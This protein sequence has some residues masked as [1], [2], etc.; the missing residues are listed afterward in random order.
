MGRPTVPDLTWWQADPDSWELLS[1][2]GRYDK[3]GLPYDAGWGDREEV[4]EMLVASPGPYS[5]DFARHLL[6][7]EILGHHHAWGYSDQIG[8]AA[9]LVAEQRRM[10]DIWLLWE[11]KSV[12]FDTYCGLPEVF[13]VA[14]GLARTL[15]YVRAG[16]GPGR[17]GLLEFLGEM[18]PV[19]DEEIAEK[20][21]RIR[22]YY[23]EL[24]A[25][26]EEETSESVSVG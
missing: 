25:L 5:A 10:E 20:L 11:A 1:F 18:S 14:N 21:T 19:S 7:Q 9:L 13:L 12:S 4:L 24:K 15:E 8:M 6:R 22:H 2:D 23:G 16:D 17:E 26:R 3:E